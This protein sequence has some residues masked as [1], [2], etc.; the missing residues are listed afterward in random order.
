MSMII[1]GIT[2]CILSVITPKAI[3]VCDSTGCIIQQPNSI[4]GVGC[5]NDIILPIRQSSNPARINWNLTV[6]TPNI[7]LNKMQVNNN[8]WTG[9]QAYRYYQ[10]QIDKINPQVVSIKTEDSSGCKSEFSVTMRIQ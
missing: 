6:W 9:N 8:T 1:C 4:L 2:A 7:L 10:V 3:P 5:N